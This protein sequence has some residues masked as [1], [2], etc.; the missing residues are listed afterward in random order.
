M[1]QFGIGQS[2][3]REEDPRLLKG[4]GQYVNDVNIPFQTHCYIIRSPHA[5]AKIKKLDVSNAVKAPGVLNIFS[6]SDVAEDNLGTPGMAAQRKRPDGSD[7]WAPPQTP[8]ALDKVRYVG[9]PIAMVIA[10]TLDQAK[11]AAELVE[12]NFET[13]PSVTSTARTIEPGC[14][15]VWDQIPDNISNVFEAGDSEA[16]EKLI[17]NAAKLVKRRFVITR[18]HA[19]FMEPRGAIGEYN[20]RNGRYT[21][22][23]D[24]QYPHRVRQVLAEKIFRIPE[25]DIRVVAGDVGGGFGAKG[26]QYVEHRLVLWASKKIGRPVKWTCERSESI[27]ADEHGRDNVTEAEL[28]LDANNNF[29]ALKVSTLANVGAY[30]SSIRNLL[31][32]FSNIGTLVGVYKI[33][34][35]H[36]KVL[37]V[38]SNTNPTAPYRGAGRPEASY[39]IERL[40]DEAAKEVGMDAAEL[41][42]RN[43]ITSSELPYKTALI[44]TYDCG[45]F[46]K[47]MN[48]ALEIS[49]Y[50]MFTERRKSS[51]LIGKLRGI[52]IANAIERAASPGPDFAEIRFSTDGTTTILMGTKNQGQGHETMYKQIAGEH[53]GL[54]SDDIRVVDGDTDQVAF[55]MGTMGSR[56]M[57]IGGSALYVAAKKIL[58]KGRTLAA[59]LLE[60]GEDDIEFK[61]GQFTVTGTDK[62]ISLKEVAKASFLPSKLPSGMEPGL[63]KTGSF[64]PEMDTFPNGCHI[65]EVEIDPETGQVEILNYSMVDD[66]GNI[67]NPLTLKG[68]IHG[69]VAQGVGQILMEHVAY[70]PQ[71]GQLLSGSLMDYAM[72]RADIM[73]FM[74]I[75]SNIVPTALNPLGVKGGGEAG[76]VGAMPALMNAI[77]NALSQIGVDHLDMPASPDRVWSAI[78]NATNNS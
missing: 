24:V 50:K 47:N 31:S 23:A 57:V 40:I 34:A 53:L 75:I 4:S 27:L 72:P 77:M 68:Q 43:I 37:C 58:E 41:R 13:L 49:E 52:G 74:Q 25:Q 3:Q 33:K 60:I 36:S 8:L 44:F 2:V 63:Y 66:V 65:V 32:T 51:A 45:E 42:Q 48:K 62:S 7:M 17:K 1:G 21:L 15:L 76:T 59:H 67:I 29:L 10:K 20:Q 56:S 18:V 26:W 30:V 71:N 54:D 12:I 19:Q 78:Q 28:A 22:Y 46:D 5:H 14:P 55:G 73:G 35:A 9:D 39:V 70:D 16:T 6:G 11:Y 64:S 61:K 38:F 69:G